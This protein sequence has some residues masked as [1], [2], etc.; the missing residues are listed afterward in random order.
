MVRRNREKTLRE[1]ETRPIGSHRCLS[2]L[3]FKTSD[4]GSMGCVGTIDFLSFSPDCNAF[5]GEEIMEGAWK[6]EE[7][8]SYF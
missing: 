6:M 7:T 4:P 8:S 1:I 3:E 2:C 5:I